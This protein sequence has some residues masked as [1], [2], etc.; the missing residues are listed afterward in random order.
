[1]R[2]AGN[3]F[4]M[5]G[6]KKQNQLL[7]IYNKD[8][9]GAATT[10]FRYPAVPGGPTTPGVLPVFA[11]DGDQSPDSITI[12]S[13]APD[14]ASPLGA[15]DQDFHSG[16]TALRLKPSLSVP[17]GL[18][19]HELLK[20]NDYLAI[21][22]PT[23]DAVLVE[24]VSDAT[25]L[26]TISIKHLP[27]GGFPNGVGEL[28]AGSEVFNVKSVTLHTYRIDESP[29]TNETFLIMDTIDSTG[30][31]MAEGIEDLQMAYCFGEDDPSNLSKY[32]NGIDFASL[33]DTF[34]RTVHLVMVARTSKPDPYRNSFNRIV[35]LNHT[36]LADPDAYPRRYLE[37]T[38]QL[39]NYFH[40]RSK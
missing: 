1:M 30:D 15:L 21:V 22:P 5:I 20:P 31:I 36:E 4:S 24:A 40:A 37:T 23:G 7:Q 33:D 11:V 16:D 3:G 39:R 28:P 26:E 32:T 29:A 8:E 2:I 25:D 17:T 9:S 10:W 35:A 18:D 34:L 13:L 12:C 38:V 14:F 27:A 6:L 19:P